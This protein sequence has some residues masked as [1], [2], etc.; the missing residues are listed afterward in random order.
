MQETSVSRRQIFDDMDFMK[1]NAGYE[2]PI[3]SIKEGRKVYYRYEDVN[4][5]I[6]KKPLNTSEINNLKEALETLGRMKNIPGFD[7]V[8]TTQT[9]LNSALDISANT[10]Q[11]ISFQENEFLKGIEFLNELYQYIINKQVLTITYQSFNAE[12]PKDFTVSPYYLKQHN[13]RWFLLSWNHAFQDIQ[14][15]AIDRIIKI[16]NTKEN[17]LDKEIDFDDYF[18]DI[19]GVTHFTDQNVQ[20]IK[21]KLSENIIP[22]IQSKPLHGSQKIKE[23]ILFL[24][25]KLNYELESLILS[26]GE[27]MT[28]LEPEILVKKIKERA[29]NLNKNY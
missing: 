25:L 13:N 11:I 24:E 8:N 17:Y 15:L 19:I 6:L 23:N 14:T 21:I 9:Q 20:T 7:W 27:T 16:E 28:V 4:F 18:E 2:A 3:T 22:Y 10:R 5:S 26:Y 29:K 1:S 12:Q